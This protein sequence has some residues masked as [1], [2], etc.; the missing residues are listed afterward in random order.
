MAVP[1]MPGRGEMST[2]FH[3]YVRHLV[4]CPDGNL[5]ANLQAIADQIKSEIGEYDP[6]VLEDPVTH[7]R[8]LELNYVQGY[9][10]GPGA[11]YSDIDYSQQVIEA[12]QAATKPKQR[13]IKEYG[14][15]Q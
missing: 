14:R 5:N 10:T 6:D 7:Q 1:E 8:R 13:R 3:Q 15:R 9:L 11:S 4:D 12:H 2:Q